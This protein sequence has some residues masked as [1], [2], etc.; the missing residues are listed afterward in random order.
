MSKQGQNNRAG[1]PGYQ[2]GHVDNFVPPAQMEAGCSWW[3]VLKDCYCGKT[4]RCIIGHSAFC[5][6]HAE[7]MLV[8][9]NAARTGKKLTIR[10][11]KS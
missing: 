8:R 3:M 4:P 1:L 2:M 5:L 7:K 9:V 11:P 10:S 6:H